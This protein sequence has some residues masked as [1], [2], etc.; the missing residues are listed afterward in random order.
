MGDIRY[1]G[2]WVSVAGWGTSHEI[3]EVCTRCGKATLVRPRGMLRYSGPCIDVVAGWVGEFEPG[4]EELLPL[5][6]VAP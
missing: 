3:H 1:C 6:E 4:G 5:A 2:P